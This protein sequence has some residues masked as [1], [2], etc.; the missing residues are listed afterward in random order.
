MKVC[1]YCNSSIPEKE[2]NCPSCGKVYWE[3]EQNKLKETVEIKESEEQRGCLS[4]FL[5]PLTLAIGVAAFLI[6][7]GFIVNLV[8]HFES[9]QVK[10][11]WIGS[12][13]LVGFAIYLLFSKIRKQKAK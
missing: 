5:V 4:L 12:S 2:E 1:P 11:I 13:L 6:T 10:I 3:P 7:A 9:N 8:V